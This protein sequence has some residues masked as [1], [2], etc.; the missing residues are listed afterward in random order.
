MPGLELEVT[1]L[2]TDDWEVFFAIGLQDAEYVDLPSGCIAPNTSF[3]AFDVDCNVADPKR[4]PD[5]T[6][7]LST[8]YN[9]AI[10]A[11]GATL[12]PTISGR[13][14]GR[15]VV[16]TRQLGVNGSEFPY[17]RGDRLNR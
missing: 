2:P 17:Q 15:N 7:T 5:S 6:W 8:T 4:S 3:A 14:I 9:W 12:R 16:G 13:Y 10:P 1:A 11:W